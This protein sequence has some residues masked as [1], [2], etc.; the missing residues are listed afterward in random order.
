[1]AKV[2]I[3]NYISDDNILRSTYDTDTNELDITDVPQN[4]NSVITLGGGGGSGE[5]TTDGIASGTEPNGSITLG[6]TVTEISDYAFAGKPIT[7]VTGPE[8]TSIRGINALKDT[9]ITEIT[10]TE[11]P[12]LGVSVDFPLSL[13]LP[14]T[15][16]KIK[17]SGSHVALSSGTAALRDCTGLVSAE[18][19]NAAKDTPAS[20]TSVGNN[21]FYGDSNLEIAD[22]GYV[23]SISSNAFYNCQALVTVVLRSTSLVSLGGTSA[24]ASGTPFKN[25]GTGGTIYIPKVLYDHLGDGTSSDYQSATNWST[26]YAYGTITWAKIEGSIYE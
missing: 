1:M 13:R 16:T 10:D 6:N 11:F 2:D 21:A 14:N 18:F 22:L 19:P 4:L 5:W 7:S 3:L 9:S 26:V 20:L 12:K 24:I 25:G 17:L 15:C 8:V 23:K